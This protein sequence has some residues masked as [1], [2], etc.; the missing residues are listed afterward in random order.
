MDRV[1][2]A[3]YLVVREKKI[4]FQQNIRSGGDVSVFMLRKALQSKSGSNGDQI[5]RH[6]FKRYADLVSAFSD[7]GDAD[8]VFIH[9]ED[10]W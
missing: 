4:P 1:F 6:C 2:C 8:N 9:E 3:S 7:S 10:S 5:C